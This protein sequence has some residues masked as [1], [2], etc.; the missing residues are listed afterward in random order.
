MG[1]AI[2]RAILSHPE[3]NIELT[4]SNRSD[5]KLRHLAN[6]FPGVKTTTDNVEAVRG[7]DMLI[8]AV[9]PY[10]LPAVKEELAD[11]TL[12][13]SIVSVVA[14]TGTAELENMFGRGRAY[15]Y[16][17]PNTPVMCG[18]GLTFISTRN[19][20]VSETEKVVEIFS[21][22]G[23]AMVIEERLMPAAMALCSC[24][25]AYAFKYIQACVQAGVELGFS[26]VEAQRLSVSTVEGAM[27]LLKQPG[28]TPQSEINRVTTPGGM[29]IKGINCLERT[30][31]VPSVIESIKAPLK[32]EKI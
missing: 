32:N 25:V 12:P 22:A 19:A 23:E 21:L 5:K 3:S 8:L 20:N 28:A 14:G 10:V 29:T 2:A 13:K 1:G 27:E 9:K 4:V 16:A 30:G 17:I 24:G 6:D 7:A 11:V 31:F 26:P 18:K 15:F